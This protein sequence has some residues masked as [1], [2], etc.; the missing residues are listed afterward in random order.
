MSCVSNFPQN[1]LRADPEVNESGALDRSGRSLLCGSSCSQPSPA[2][3]RERPEKRQHT[4]G[5][6]GHGE[7]EGQGRAMCS[8]CRPLLGWE[9]PQP[10]E[11]GQHRGTQSIS[12][13][14]GS[15]IHTST[16]MPQSRS[17]PS[18]WKSS[19]CLHSYPGARVSSN[20][21]NTTSIRW[22]LTP[23]QEAC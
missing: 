23:C 20:K 14:K 3:P 5:T 21:N 4:V 17:G 16:A 1:I 2:Q 8:G 13:E 11:A 9:A 18:A 15:H 22:A 6:R 10:Q 12:P 7:Q 19:P